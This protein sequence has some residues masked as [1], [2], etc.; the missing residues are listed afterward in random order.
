MCTALSVG[1]I[2]CGLQEVLK[3]LS[4]NGVVYPVPPPKEKMLKIFEETVAKHGIVTGA[5]V[6]TIFGRSSLRQVACLACLAAQMR[7]L[8]DIFKSLVDM[9]GLTE[10]KI[11]DDDLFTRF[12]LAV[13]LLLHATASVRK[14]ASGRSTPKGS[15]RGER[16]MLKARPHCGHCS[17]TATP[18]E[19][20]SRPGAATP[21][22]DTSSSNRPRTLSDGGAEAAVVTAN[23]ASAFQQDSVF[24]SI[25]QKRLI[26]C[27]RGSSPAAL[28]SLSRRMEGCNRQKLLWWQSNKRR[29]CL[30]SSSRS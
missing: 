3:I 12:G 17:G 5:Q 18:R 28:R 26:M 16:N 2:G 8:Q 24:V 11:V 29:L 13:Q 30:R 10:T 20:W 19:G 9:F 1:L 4:D 22:D 21:R 6:R 14:S 23:V 25:C 27:H 15:T 7:C